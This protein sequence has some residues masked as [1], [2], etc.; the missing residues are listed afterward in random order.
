MG[1]H[2]LAVLREAL[3]NVAHH[4]QATTVEVTVAAGGQDLV[5]RVEDNGVGLPA[6]AGQGGGNGLANMV[7]RADKLDGTCELTRPVLRGPSSN[8]ASRWPEREPLK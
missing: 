2:L 7:A 1:D 5:L 4:A 8:G 6:E 3:S